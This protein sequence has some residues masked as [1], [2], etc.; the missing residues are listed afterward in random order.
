MRQSNFMMGGGVPVVVKNLLIINVVV[1]IFCITF[2]ENNILT[3][4]VWRYLPKFDPQN[5]LA[6]HY[7]DSS[8]FNLAQMV[9]YM[10][11]HSLQDM[12]HLFF[13]MFSL[14]MFGSAVE[15]ALG[16]KRFLT[17]YM[18]SG[19]GA[20]I[21]QE[22]FWTIDLQ[23]FLARFSDLSNLANNTL[24]SVNGESMTVTELLAYRDG[25]LSS[26]TTVGASGAVFGLLLA[27]GMLFSES[28]I[29]VFF[30]LPVKAKYFVVFYALVELFCGVRVATSEASDG[31]AH[32]AHLGGM[33]FG[34]LLMLYW[35]KK[36][37]ESGYG[38]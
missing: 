27:Y 32:F 12:S 11:L 24:I 20:A 5:M 9:T 35:R 28:T 21:V 37:R 38:Y 7:W 19:I 29:Y 2:Q 6:L 36:D 34:L 23:R 16:P 33:L 14:F 22:V 3:D 26:L 8:A 18:I 1:Y 10:F 30:V 13:N 4:F 25:V 31:I 17:F 15:Y